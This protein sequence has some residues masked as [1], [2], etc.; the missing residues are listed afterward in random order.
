MK[1]SPMMTKLYFKSLIF[2]DYANKKLVNSTDV[3]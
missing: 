2:S 3:Y 1:K